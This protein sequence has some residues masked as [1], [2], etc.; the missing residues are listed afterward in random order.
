[1]GDR[2]DTRNDR[3]KNSVGDAGGIVFNTIRYRRSETVQTSE[4]FQNYLCQLCKGRNN[5]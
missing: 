2:N 4:D 5:I 1:M 3:L